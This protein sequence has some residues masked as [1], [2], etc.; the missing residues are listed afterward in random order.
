MDNSAP[1][2]KRLIALLLAEEEPTQMVVHA[3][4][5]L[6]SVLI[7]RLDTCALVRASGPALIEKMKYF[8]NKETNFLANHRNDFFYAMM[9]IFDPAVGATDPNLQILLSN[10]GFFVS[11]LLQA[12]AARS[13]LYSANLLNGLTNLVSYVGRRMV[14]PYFAP[15][16][17][18][19]VISN[20]LDTQTDMVNSVSASLLFGNYFS[21]ADAS[22]VA[23]VARLQTMVPIIAHVVQAAVTD[24]QYGGRTWSPKGACEALSNLSQYNEFHGA[25][26][27]CDVARWLVEVLSRD[28][29]VRSNYLTLGAAYYSD[30]LG[31]ASRT[32]WNL[33]FA[34]RLDR[35]K[36]TM[37]AERM[38]FL[39]GALQLSPNLTNCMSAL[40]DSFLA[41]AAIMERELMPTKVLFDAA[42][43]PHVILIC[44]PSPRGEAVDRVL[45]RTSRMAMKHIQ[46]HTLSGSFLIDAVRAATAV[47]VL[48]TPTLFE[49]QQANTALRM[50]VS[51]KKTLYV[52]TSSATQ[53]ED[54]KHLLP[55]SVSFTC[56]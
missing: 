40:R 51:F 36:C 3:V 39:L 30:A 27:S 31:Y 26:V 24:V 48:H 55:C 14:E 9:W 50:S 19:G 13:K 11:E 17:V 22:N 1:E 45:R 46:S 38:Q 28:W 41:Q 25:L 21:H 33:R 37:L 16:D 52:V 18:L 4:Q 49:S 32:L 7:C 44:Q 35:D 8:L 54:T 43:S 23:M 6:T 15:H 56:I 42:A 29:T 20:L 47:Y 10:T 5:Q 2:V 53:D 12:T 34:V